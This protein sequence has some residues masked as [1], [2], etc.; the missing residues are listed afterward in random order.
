[1]GDSWQYDCK[2]SFFK[3]HLFSLR[4]FLYSNILLEKKLKI[5]IISHIRRLKEMLTETQKRGYFPLMEI[6]YETD[7][8]TVF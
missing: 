5:K 1:M 4:T 2:V 6:V 7:Y 3:L 8:N